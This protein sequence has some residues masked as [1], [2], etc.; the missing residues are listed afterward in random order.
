MIT[1]GIRYKKFNTYFMFLTLISFCYVIT[2]L[3]YPGSIRDFYK[4]YLIMYATVF[5]LYYSFS[6]YGIGY[7][8]N[9]YKQLT[10]A[11]NIFS[12]LNLYQVFFHKPLLLNYMILIQNSYPYHFYQDSYR[13]LSVFGHPIIAGLFF[14]VLFFCNLYLI[15]NPIKY[16]LQ[17]IV[18]INIYSTMARSTWI[19]FILG[20][21][22]Y[23]IMHRKKGYVK[24]F[25]FVHV[26][27]YKRFLFTYI[28]LIILL[29]AGAFFISHFSEISSGIMTRIGDSL[30][31]N[32][33]DSSN[34]QRTGTINLVI[35]Y[36]LQSNVFHIIFGYGF[37]TMIAFLLAHPLLIAGF[38]ST[39]NIYL[40]VFYQYGLI[41]VLAYLAL[42]VS[43]FIKFF[44]SKRTWVA[45]LSL[46]SFIVVS[47]S[48]F[49]FEYT[50]WQTVSIFLMFILCCL[51]FPFE[52]EDAK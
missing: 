29:F 19:A 2:F 23:L 36:M 28:S 42:I 11:L 14:A 15:K 22:F 52:K 34:L 1:H 16:V 43:I 4:Y 33:T 7:A 41:G 50:G 49:F 39:D 13:T 26:I 27:T 37:N 10:V 48:S 35:G 38:G 9:F 12:V 17:F 51:T 8:E 24:Q 30:S 31:Q 18:L 44:N 40:S 21:L 45:E 47:I 25:P 5:Y 3:F 6:R 32:S 46:I 20:L